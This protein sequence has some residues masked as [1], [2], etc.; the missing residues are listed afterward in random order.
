MNE[1]KTVLSLVKK[2][3]A[4]ESDPTNEQTQDFLNQLE[5]ITGIR[6]PKR[7]VTDLTP[8][9]WRG[10][11]SKFMVSLSVELPLGTQRHQ[12]ATADYT[13]HRPPLSPVG[14]G[15]TIFLHRPQ[16]H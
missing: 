7:L 5:E 11:I 1:K 8:E 9:D 14:K 12:K 16:C 15:S 3:V 2:L 6:S 4:M 13:R 10:I